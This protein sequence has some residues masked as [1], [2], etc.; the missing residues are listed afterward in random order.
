MIGTNKGF[1]NLVLVS[2]K[3]VLIFLFISPS[4]E[5]LPPKKSLWFCERPFP[6]YY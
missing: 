1:R 3:F 5:V 4:L 2:V 6:F